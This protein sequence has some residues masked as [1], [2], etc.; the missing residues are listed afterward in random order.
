MDHIV[1]RKGHKEKYDE[2]KVYASV[3]AACLVLRMTDDE[4]ELIANMVAHEVTQEF[5][6]V[7]EVNA[8]KIHEFT[9]KSLKKYNPSAAYIY[10][11]HK[12]IS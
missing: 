8:H 12:D 6:K 7:K 11:T 1:K 2:R 10:D 9:A 4:A 3:F 5:K